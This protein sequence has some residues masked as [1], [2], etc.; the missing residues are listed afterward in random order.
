MRRKTRHL[1]IMQCPSR[2]KDERRHRKWDNNEGE[3][4]Y[5]I[6]G[7]G[8]CAVPERNRSGW[9]AAGGEKEEA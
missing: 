7:E 3:K 8:A 6:E 9:R 2:K 5:C 1:D 4:G